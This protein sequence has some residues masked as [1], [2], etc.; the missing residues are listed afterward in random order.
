MLENETIERYNK[1][2]VMRRFIPYV[3][4]TDRR[5]AGALAPG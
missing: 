1:D 4:S 5:Q 2:A 3:F